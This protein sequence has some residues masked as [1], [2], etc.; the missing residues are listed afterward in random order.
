MMEHTTD[1]LFWTLTSII[2]G[3]LILTIGINAFPKA[4]Q[5]VIQP[6]SGITKQADTA[7][8]TV[9]SAVKSQTG[10]TTSTE[11]PED[12]AAKANAVDASSLF[13]TVSDN[14]DG[15]GSITAFNKDAA[16]YPSSITIPPYIK[17]NGKVLKITTIGNAAFKQTYISSLSLPDT[18]TYIGEDAFS[19]NRMT[20]VT[21]P[22]SVKK[23]GHMAFWSSSKMRVAH[24]SKNTD[25]G[26]EDI[27]VF[28]LWVQ[29]D[30]Y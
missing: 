20:Q 23:I 30:L 3:A 13:M 6:I 1:R 18:V 4:T 16:G 17:S 22:A 12:A 15:T 9:D 11:S 27:W 26:T 10:Q 29:K 14:G 21:I 24:I 2:I 7:T 5:G 25:I 19:N 28:P 8:S